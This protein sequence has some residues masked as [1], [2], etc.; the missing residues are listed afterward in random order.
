MEP[1]H[2]A[3]LIACLKIVEIRGG[4]PKAIVVGGN[5]LVKRRC[6]SLASEA[7]FVAKPRDD[8]Q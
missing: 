4:A 5:D 6:A 2:K 1:A 3:N 8:F 7:I